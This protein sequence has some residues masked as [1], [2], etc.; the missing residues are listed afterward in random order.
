MP[1]A[2]RKFAI[3]YTYIRERA[4]VTTMAR[5]FAQV[6][7]DKQML[8][9]REKERERRASKAPRAS[10]SLPVCMSINASE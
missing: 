9:E 2:K 8:R 6:T 4:V 5:E 1:T 10:I 3:E 7:M